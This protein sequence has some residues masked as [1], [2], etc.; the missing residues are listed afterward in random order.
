M[1]LITPELQGDYPRAVR[2][3]GVYLWDDQGRRYLD[4]SSGS[5][6]A[7]IGHGHPRVAEVM[8][9]QAL[10]L[11]FVMRTQFVNEPATRLATRIVDRWAP[12]GL[13]HVW[14]STSGSDAVEF[15]IRIA[16]QYHLERGEGSR[17]KVLSM[18]HSYHGTTFGALAA[19]GREGQ[20][21]MHHPYFSGA[22]H[23]VAAPYAY[24][25]PR[26]CGRSCAGWCADDIEA[27]ILA[28]GPESVSAVLFEPVLGN[29]VGA[30]EGSAAY[31]DRLREICSAHGVLT[32]ADE[33]LTGFG[34]T[35]AA[36]AGDHWGVAPDIL[37]CGKGLGAGY[38]PLFATL[39]T[40]RVLDTLAAGSG[41]V[42]LG[43]TY[44][45]HPLSCA[46]GDAVLDVLEHEDAVAA[47]ARHG[48]VVGA[49]LDDLADRHPMIGDVRGRGLF[50]AVELVRDRD[51]REPF[52]PGAGAA[53]A[54]AGA[55]RELGLLLFFRTGTV[56]GVS[57][58]HVTI[59]P[60]LT[61]SSE[62]LTELLETFAAAL[63]AV[64]PQL[65][66]DPRERRQQPAS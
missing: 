6:C 21:S 16:R 24:R 34:R 66:P 26:S 8:R 2:G 13:S 54:V 53:S 62:E 38:A 44:C 56:D 31:F 23:K 61:I 22:W 48:L 55:C 46:V 30:V 32:I 42:A 19:S 43:N 52:P 39:V 49:A 9:H 11:P 5:V 41:L 36:F 25:C 3:Q 57:G 50:W 1:P 17:H 7:N 45:A 14:F 58:D 63:D 47:T 18:R 65:D 40:D 35:G 60:P 51:S 27:V 28:E 4:G 33:V 12:A 10:T 37:A 20:R 15:A 29:T 64:G 59:A